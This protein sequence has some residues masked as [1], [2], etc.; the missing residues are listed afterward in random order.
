MCV[1]VLWASDLNTVC[2]MFPERTIEKVFV[3]YHETV[4]RTSKM[5]DIIRP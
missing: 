4:E 3:L 5:S 2:P 1:C